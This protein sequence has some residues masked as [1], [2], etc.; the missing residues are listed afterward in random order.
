MRLLLSLS[1]VLLL[2]AP[3]AAQVRMGTGSDGRVLLHNQ[4]GMAYSGAS[5]ALLQ[6]RADLAESI[7]RH[8]ERRGLDPLLVRAVIQVESGYNSRAVSRK[9]AIGLM[10]LMP[11]TAAEL[12]VAD[13]FDPDAN[14]RGGTD[15][16]RR[17]LDTFDN[18]LSLALAGYNAGP[19][20]VRRYGGVPPYQETREYV[21]RVLRLYQGADFAALPE[22]LE[23]DGRQT[24]IVRRDGR[25]VMTT[26]PPSQH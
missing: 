15:Y 25:L 7:E 10:Q 1:A 12:R 20:A 19:E 4:G 22:T 2:G 24:Y 9:G 26:T 3:V 5:Q 16:L 8:A 11:G 13:P 17:M 21:R 18:K 6:P 14:I 23:A